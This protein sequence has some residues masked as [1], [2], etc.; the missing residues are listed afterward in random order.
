MTE[1]KRRRA[2]VGMIPQVDIPILRTLPKQG[3]NLGL[4]P[5]GATASYLAKKHSEWEMTT[6]EIAGRL[7][8]LEFF[9]YVVSVPLIPARSGLGWQITKKGERK[10]AEGGQA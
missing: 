10:L 9:G 7:K 4:K 3:T 2:D 8:S 1:I 5:Q 6:T